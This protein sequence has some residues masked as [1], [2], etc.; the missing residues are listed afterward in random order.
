MSSHR[1]FCRVL[2]EKR[3]QRGKNVS[4]YYLLNSDS[5]HIKRL[6]YSAIKYTF[7]VFMSL[8]YVNLVL[9]APV[10]AEFKPHLSHSNVFSRA[11]QSS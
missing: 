3:I 8:P 2:E 1:R 10:Q 11:V 9:Y 6:F 5:I 7:E 4:I